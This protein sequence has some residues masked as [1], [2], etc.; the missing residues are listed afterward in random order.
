MM[1]KFQNS[2]RVLCLMSL[3]ALSLSGPVM[4]AEAGDPREVVA[5]NYKDL[6]AK[7]EAAA[8]H[9]D[10]VS[11]LKTMLAGIVN[12]DQF[13]AR[14]LKGVWKGLKATDK[15]RFKD[16]FTRLVIKT[17]AKRF[18][19][20]T[21]FSVT[22]RKDTEWLDEARTAATVFTVVAGAKVSADVDYLFKPTQIAGA[23]VW[24]AADIVIDGVSMALNWR[25]SFRRIVNRDGF[26]ALLARI[27]KQL[28]K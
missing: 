21:K 9:E 12:Y 3:M 25:K 22:F 16:K 17:Y 26:E 13:A 14:T 27:D 8:T 6:A 18:K 20:K 24:R 2:G 11:A 5:S 7:T 1:C 28:A 23:Q 4:A 10:I 15:D 19:P